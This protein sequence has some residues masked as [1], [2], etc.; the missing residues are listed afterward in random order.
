MEGTEHTE[1]ARYV[2]EQVALWLAND[3]DHAERAR[4][5]AQRD[6]SAWAG[7]FPRLA[8][9]VITVLRNPLSEGAAAWH[10]ARELAPNDYAR[11]RW[12]DV[13]HQLVGE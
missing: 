11:I 1:R 4:T 8:E 10:V 3:G 6:A 13:A 2:T 5:L 12:A 9:Y 7:D